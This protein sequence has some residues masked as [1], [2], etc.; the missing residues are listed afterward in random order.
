MNINGAFRFHNIGQGLFYSGL[1][2]KSDSNSQSTFSFVYDCGTFSSK[3]LLRQEIDAYKLLLPGV[4]NSR[5]KKLDLLIVSHLHDDHVNG[6]EYLLKDVD[7]ETVVMPYV[8]DGLKLLARLE[9]ASDNEFLQTFYL[10]PV[11][12]FISKGVRRI[13]LLGSDDSMFQKDDPAIA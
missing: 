13:L 3:T 11:A 4:R 12:W 8:D 2:N 10:D 6:L 7:V 9:S 5:N 1:L